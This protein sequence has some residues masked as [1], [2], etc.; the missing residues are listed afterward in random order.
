MGNGSVNV[1]VVASTEERA[2]ELAKDKFK[3]DAIT[4]QK[5]DNYYKN[6]EVEMI[7]NTDNE[8]IGQIED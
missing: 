4:H 7:C 2:L 1:L 8:Y 5:S 6:L 3:E